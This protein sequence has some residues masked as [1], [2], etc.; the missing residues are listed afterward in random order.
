MP[1]GSTD[2]RLRRM[3]LPIIVSNATVPLLGA[4]DTAVVGHLPDHYSYEWFAKQPNTFALRFA[5]RFGHYALLLSDAGA[6]VTAASN[7]E[8]ATDWLRASAASSRP[9]TTVLL[10]A[11]LSGKATPVLCGT[12]LRNKGVQLLLDAICDYLP[13]PEEMPPL[14]VH[15]PAGVTFT[16]I[17]AEA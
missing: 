4:V 17:P 12:A 15:C 1:D 6:D 8:E 5:S 14:A 9:F 3:A 7:R 16:L 13:S 2:R 10:D 11:T